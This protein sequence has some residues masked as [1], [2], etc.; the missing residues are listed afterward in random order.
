MK[1]YILL[2]TILV[3]FSAISS[4][5][6]WVKMMSDPHANFYDV[7]KSFNEWN[8]Q[9]LKKSDDKAE[10]NNQGDDEAKD[11]S[12]ELYKRW[13]WYMEPR[14]YPTGNMPAGNPD[15]EYYE[16][17]IA[18]QATERTDKTQ[19]VATWTYSGNTTVPGGGGAGRVNRLCFYPG[20]DSII[21]ACTPFGGLWKSTNGGTSWSTNT[22]QL[23]SIATSDLAINP[24]NPKV[25]YLATG[26]GD[27]W[28]QASIGI[29][30]SYD[31]G[32]T[33]DTTSLYWTLQIS[34]PSYFM[35]TRVLINPD[36]TALVLAGMSNGLFVSSNSGATWKQ[37]LNEDVK[38]I[39]F[40]PY[41]PST[42]YVGTY[43]GK[44]FR[45]VDSGFTFVMD[46]TD[47]PASGV[48]RMTVGVS[49]ADSN[50]VYVLA[51]N[52]STSGY[53]GLY[54]STDRG[55]TFTPKSLFSAGAPNLL[56]WAQNGNDSTGQGWYTLSLAVSPTNADSLMVGGVN[57][58]QSADSGGAWSLIAQWTGS[59]APYVHAD[60]HELTYLP[61]SGS[62]Y[63]AACDGGVFTRKSNYS[64]KWTDI[65]NNL[66]IGQQYSI[67]LSSLTPG[68]WISG[69]Q[70]NGTNVSG[71]P[72][73]QIL[74]GDGEVCFIDYT[75][76]QNMFA[77]YQ[78][79][80]LEASTDGGTSWYSATNG[81]SETGPWTT[82]WLQDPQQTNVLFAGFKNIWESGD[83]AVSWA[84]FTTWGT[85]QIDAIAIAPS[86]D[87]YI[88]ASQGNSVFATAD[89]GVTWTNISGGLPAGL[90]SCTALAVDP[91]NPQRVWATF[92]GWV[93]NT[94]V[95]QSDD[96]GK[97]WKNIS[98][99][100]PNLP[101]NCIVAQ[102]GSPDGIY[103]GTDIGVYYHDTVL[104]NWINYSKGLP[105]VMVDDLKI[106][107]PNNTLVAATYGR[108]TW[109]V[110][111][112]YLTSIKEFS[113]DRDINV[114]PN[115]TKGK[116][117]VQFAMPGGD[118]TLSVNNLLGQTLLTKQLHTSGPYTYSIDMSDY[119]KGMYF[120]T[121]ST[122]T[123]RTVKKI[124]VE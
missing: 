92:S 103:V 40:E 110:P 124:V 71:S 11:G 66:E 5:Q 27:G 114:F 6:N 34:G 3:T 19:S 37:T 102:E 115:P 7:Q 31:G 98:S 4:A 30:K 88:Y 45:S 60:I 53:Y 93:S 80:S 56:G 87:V 82:R 85:G 25:M 109:S 104:N 113:L 86:N 47:F 81:I 123:S 116:V 29:L 91:S 46:S 70:D 14:V 58:W 18:Q 121:I 33:W 77:S 36:D 72:W 117:Q 99:G 15:A 57:V 38:S 1:K 59:G 26:D 119:G 74:G 8:A 44:F 54:I 21:Y 52:S 105:N 24:V 108:G 10:Q 118:F 41:H 76:D 120:V 89:E 68:L 97:L 55:Q 67:G 75:N 90:V 63:Y 69:W 79:G 43:D 106:Y 50:R 111:T 9:R 16:K 62:A 101:V 65:S 112:Y 17:Y 22:D 73:N 94:K 32:N 20:N 95:Y 100:L 39:E 2:T 28:D 107:A 13:E 78:N 84:Q 48:G 23:K 61:G 64:G 96:G 35:G 12:Y 51:E 83:G 49:P 42:V 122:G